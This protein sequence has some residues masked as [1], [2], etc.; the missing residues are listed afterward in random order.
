MRILFYHTRAVFFGKGGVVYLVS[1]RR[2]FGKWYEKRVFVYR[3]DFK[4]ARCARSRHDDV[5]SRVEKGNVVCVLELMIVVRLDLLAF[6]LARDVKHEIFCGERFYI[7]FHRI[8]YRACSRRAAEH[9]K[10]GLFERIVYLKSFDCGC[11]VFVDEI[12]SQRHPYEYSVEFRV[13]ICFENRRAFKFCD[14]VCQAESEVALVREYR[15]VCLF[16]RKHHGER[17]EAAF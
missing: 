7:L 2:A 13:R 4:Y 1:A 6:V 16:C 17:Y 9:E 15:Y 3:R 8:V 12:V 10:H 5:A 14:F 11:F